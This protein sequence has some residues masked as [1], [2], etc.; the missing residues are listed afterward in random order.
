MLQLRE[1]HP[2]DEGKYTCIVS[3]QY[4]S[5]EHTISVDSIGKDVHVIIMYLYYTA[6]ISSNQGKKISITQSFAM[7]LQK[8]VFKVD[9]NIVH[10]T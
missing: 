8:N 2:D 4:G 10:F 3:N 7:S 6:K 1:L 5:F 9:R